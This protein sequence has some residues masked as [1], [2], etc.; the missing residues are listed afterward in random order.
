LRNIPASGIGQTDPK[1]GAWQTGI[2][3]SGSNNTLKN[4]TIAYSSHNGVYAHGTNQTVNNCTIHDVLYIA[5]EGGAVSWMGDDPTGATPHT[6]G[7]TVTNN[8]LYTS[9]RHL[10]NHYYA[11][12]ILIAHN[13]MYDACIQ[14]GDCGFTYTNKG[15]NGQPGGTIAYNWG[16]D[17]RAAYYP[18]GIYLDSLT[19]N[20]TVHHNVVWNIP[21]A[22]AGINF[23]DS[24]NI[25]VYNNS[26]WQVD[27]CHDILKQ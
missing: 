21:D 13:L 1:W 7:H 4:C 3:L 26:V 16:H 14:V 2:R 9:G 8:T 12:N 27:N 24:Q 6:S 25:K 5:S 23:S 10:I 19:Q 15:Q 18:F 11:P 22:N 17:N 20:Y